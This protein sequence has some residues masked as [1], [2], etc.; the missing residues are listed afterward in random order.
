MSIF[1]QNSSKENSEELL[2]Q[3]I[4]DDYI[5]SNELLYARGTNHLNPYVEEE[6]TDVEED[7]EYNHSNNPKTNDNILVYIATLLLSV[8]GLLI[9]KKYN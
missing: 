5:I 2:Y 7:Y 3:A 1:D 4:K 8:S 9:I 6:I